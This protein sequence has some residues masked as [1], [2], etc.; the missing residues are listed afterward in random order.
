M[1]IYFLSVRSLASHI[2]VPQKIHLAMI[3]PCACG[4]CCGL[5]IQIEVYFFVS[6]SSGKDAPHYFHPYVCHQIILSQRLRPVSSNCNRWYP[7]L[8][9]SEPKDPLSI[10]QRDREEKCLSNRTA[11]IKAEPNF[12]AFMIYS[13]RMLVQLTGPS[14]IDLLNA[15]YSTNDILQ[16]FSAR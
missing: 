13:S 8:Q 10:P 9:Q 11:T 1:S 16:L 5:V 7:P 15:V 4:S 6:K 14:N 12:V 3:E 2:L